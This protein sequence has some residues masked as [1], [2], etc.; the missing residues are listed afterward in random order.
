MLNKKYAEYPHALWSSKDLPFKYMEFGYFSSHLKLQY[1][2][3]RDDGEIQL[4]NAT[5]I[6]TAAHTEAWSQMDEA[7]TPMPRISVW[8]RWEIWLMDT[9]LREE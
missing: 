3:N 5:G 2:Y 8:Q 7:S 4:I 1:T 6:V 9:F